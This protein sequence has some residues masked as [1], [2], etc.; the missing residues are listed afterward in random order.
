M[1]KIIIILNNQKIQFEL[2]LTLIKPG[3]IVEYENPLLII[4][5]IIDNK[6]KKYHKWLLDKDN[7]KFF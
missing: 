6:N 7:I 3:D 5:S 4:P 1:D 2:A